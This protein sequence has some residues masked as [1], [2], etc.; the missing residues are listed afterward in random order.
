MYDSS[1]SGR[2]RVIHAADLHLDSPFLGLERYE[3]APVEEMVG[4]TRAAFVNLVDLAVSQEVS[5][6]LLAGDIYDGDWPDYNTG[7]FFAKQLKRLQ[8]ANVRVVIVNGNHDAASVISKHLR[9]PANTTVLAHAKPQTV[10]FDDLGIAVTGQSF[11]TREITT[12]LSQGFPDPVEGLFNFGLLHTSADGRP[13][14]ERYAPC[15][16]AELALRGYDYWALGHVHNREIVSEAPWVVFSGSLQGRHARETGA[17]GFFLIEIESNVVASVT[18]VDV[19]VVRWEVVTLDVTD[20]TTIDDVTASFAEAAAQTLSLADGR[21]VAARVALHGATRAHAT[22]VRDPDRLRAHL[23]EAAIEVADSR[24][25]IERIQLKTSTPARVTP[26]VGRDESTT[27]L[28]AVL[29]DTDKEGELAAL[30]EA[31]TPL[32]AKLPIDL[33]RTEDGIDVVGGAEHVASLIPQIEALLRLELSQQEV[34]Q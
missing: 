12:D 25:W 7:L 26:L 32:R 19:D 8:D 15:K 5:L 27:E 2:V 31:L 6:V 24:L 10:T 33:R 4:A 28:V 16:P 17:K 9:L 14:H 22:L 34:A 18:P 29:R 21:L 3:G 13:G 1:Y 30:V 11:S 20:A 23:C